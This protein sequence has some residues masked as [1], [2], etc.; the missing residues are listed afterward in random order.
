MAFT[1]STTQFG[2]VFANAV[3]EITEANLEYRLNNFGGG[4]EGGDTPAPTTRLRIGYSIYVDQAAKDAGGAAMINEW[5]ESDAGADTDIV[6]GDIITLAEAII[7][8][9]IEAPSE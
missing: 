6:D 4:P 7:K 8:A 5:D 2:H 3:V 9:K 1:A